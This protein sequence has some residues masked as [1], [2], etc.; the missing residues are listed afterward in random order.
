MIILTAFSAFAYNMNI[1]G[2]PFN[3]MSK[4]F[5]P[6]DAA[7]SN[8][9][10]YALY[11]DPTILSNGKFSLALP[12][13]SITHYNTSSF[14]MSDAGSKFAADLVR[15]Q[16]DKNKVYSALYSLVDSLGVGYNDLLNADV[17]V[18]IAGDNWVMGVN[19][20]TVTDLY[21]E[22]GAGTDA[23]IRPMVDV[24]GSLGFNIGLIENDSFNLNFAVVTRFAYRAYTKDTLTVEDIEQFDIESEE[25]TSGWAVPVDVSLGTDLFDGGLRFTISATNLNGYYYMADHENYKSAIDI[26]GGYN[27]RTVYTPWSLNA[28]VIFNPDFQFINPKVR[29]EFVD[30]YNYVLNEN[31]KEEFIS[32]LNI[33]AEVKLFD[34]ISIKGALNSGYWQIGAGLD[35]AGNN[36]S[37]LYGWHEA[38]DM[39]GYKPVDSLTLRV[40]LG[41]DG[42]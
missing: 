14:L 38:G 1:P 31:G 40:T 22:L 30:I 19:A 16:I 34:F 6:T 8:Y 20:R 26:R 4:A 28:A 10:T 33:G 32:H 3:S 21:S 29:V 13:V 39:L 35:V 42:N 37:L 25:I 9:V 2:T 36:I 12:S 41:Y 24:A 17:N 7:E 15:F 11:K 5:L 27:S 23:K 18:G